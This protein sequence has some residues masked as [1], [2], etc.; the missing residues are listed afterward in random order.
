VFTLDL[1]SGRNTNR[2]YSRAKI[3]D[4]IFFQEGFNRER[5]RS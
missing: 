5:S 4:M 1:D 2:R 3:I